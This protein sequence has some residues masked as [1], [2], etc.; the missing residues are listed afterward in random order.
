MIHAVLPTRYGS[1]RFPGKFIHLLLGTPMLVHVYDGVKQCKR[2]DTI[3]LAT[4]SY[5]IRN[6][7][8]SH[9]IP[10]VMTSSLHENGTERVAEVADIMKWPDSDLVINV[11]VD[12]PTIKPEMIDEVLN[13]WHYGPRD[14]VTLYR[15]RVSA[16]SENTVK[17]VGNWNSDALYF[18]RSPIPYNLL[19]SVRLEHVGIY[20]Y[21][22]D[23]LR[24]YS[25]TKQT[26][27]EILEDLEQLRF[28]EHGKK[29]GL[30]ETKHMT[31]PVNVPDDV[32]A[33]E[34]ELRRM[35]R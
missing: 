34:T 35:G 7:A 1:T 25:G 16:V 27:L 3:T 29:I 6:V 13:H 11:Q 31:Y 21:R 9:D 20:L 18:S 17:V 32:E 2:I 10:V 14:V 26:N 23:T 28:I 33:A 8:L 4:D 15:K 12:E 24:W 19:L 30:V 22:V 5:R